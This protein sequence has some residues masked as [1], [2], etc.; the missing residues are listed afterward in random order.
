MWRKGANPA[1]AGMCDYR[2]REAPV[3]AD[4]DAE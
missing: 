2:V 4:G 3:L 1:T